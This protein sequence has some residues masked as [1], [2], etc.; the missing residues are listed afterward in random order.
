MTALT[1][2]VAATAPAGPTTRR[3]RLLI[4]EW[5]VFAAAYAQIAAA[6]ATFALAG[7]GNVV[8]LAFGTVLVLRTPRNPIGTMMTV[9]GWG[10]MVVISV[11]VG[12]HQ[13]ADSGSTTLGG[14]IALIAMLV[15]APLLWINLVAIW[16]VF[17][18]GRP[19]NL[20]AGRILRWS[21]WYLVVPLTIGVFATPRVLGPGVE[22][23]P[24]PFVDPSVAEAA[25]FAWSLS[26]IVLFVL[27]FVAVGLLLGR[28]READPVERRQ[29]L[30]VCV[31]VLGYFAVLLVS[32]FVQPMDGADDWSFLVGDA[33]ANVLIATALGIAMTRY[34]LF[35]IGRV[36]R[37]SV[38]FGGLA[39]TIAAIYVTVVVG[40]GAYYGDDADPVLAVAAT[41]AVA[42]VFQPARRALE[43]WANHL[44]YGPRAEPQEVLSRFAR[45]SMELTDDELL[46][47]IPE[48]VA[49][50]TSA[51]R[52]ALW[53]RTEDGSRTESVWPPDST[54]RPPATLDMRDPALDVPGEDR[55][56]P[57]FH[58][59]ELL[60]GLAV[61]K[62]PGEPITPAEIALLDD[63]A[64]ALGVAMRNARL[65]T[66]LRDE[67]AALEASRERLLTADDAARRSLEWALD[68]GP[69]QRLV[70]LKVKL[71][72]VR[73]Q[74]ER[75][76][77]NRVA[78]LLGA[79]EPET[80][81]A[82]Q[83]IRRFAAGVYPAEL[84]SDGLAAAIRS[85]G[86]SVP[87][88]LDV[89]DLDDSCDAASRFDRDIESAV[90]FTVLEALQNV[91]KHADAR[92]VE[93]TLRSAPNELSF[94]VVDDGDGFDAGTRPSGA[95]LVGMADRLDTVG[96]RL[97][98]ESRPGAGTTVS[99]RVPLAND[100]VAH[101]EGAPPPDV[102]RSHDSASVSMPNDDLGMKVVAP[103]A[104]AGPSKSPDSWVDS[105]NT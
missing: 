61:E 66:D 40:V 22:P 6:G 102:A 103:A 85:G 1:S 105:T 50:G 78:E 87:F 3:R 12:A 83:A 19:A 57:V 45:R 71:G 64:G 42:L 31:G 39:M 58:E 51:R 97:V 20:R 67:L 68:S 56:V 24:H 69:Q 36:V 34:R 99:G 101:D 25:E 8:F 94:D 90:Y 47:R 23:A 54:V 44:V 59:G 75:L 63:L 86:G 10:W 72:P 17:P 29:I 73:V 46:E 30:V 33:L 62:E 18:D 11:D 92:Q 49:E 81:L 16:L 32:G 26:I 5:L 28:L 100:R 27:G 2:P 79:L 53:V 38:V 74:A 82:I 37:R 21:A 80:E 43:R 91:A 4:L 104:A 96:G 77:S 76:G 52:V 98:V 15:T 48:L 7:I 84:E 60:G 88:D 70:A 55:S 14:W 13:L 89:Q 41:V 9:N 93:V 35:E 95:G 65:A